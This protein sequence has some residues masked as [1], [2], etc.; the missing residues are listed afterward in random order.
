MIRRLAL[1][2]LFIV[3]FL[4]LD[5]LLLTNWTIGAYLT[6]LGYSAPMEWLQHQ[7]GLSGA[8]DRHQFMTGLCDIVSVLVAIGAVVLASRH[9]RRRV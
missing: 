5:R 4:A 1:I 3:V 2:A 9:S 8:D 7:L 6:E